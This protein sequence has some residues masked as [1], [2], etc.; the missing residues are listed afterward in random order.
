MVPTHATT[1]TTLNRLS[2]TETAALGR[3][4]W[5]TDLV[6]V[7]SAGR[8]MFFTDPAGALELVTEHHDAVTADDRPAM[9]QA[10]T[11][12]LKTVAA[13]LKEQTDA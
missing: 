1:I 7:M 4:S 12:G 11:E 8:A 5:L 3:M 6:Q 9:R 10:L 2:L 13:K